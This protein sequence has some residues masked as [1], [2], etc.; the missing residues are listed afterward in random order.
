MAKEIEFGSI[1]TATLN[2]EAV[3]GKANE[4]EENESEEQK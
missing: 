3:L 1:S 4:K 2:I